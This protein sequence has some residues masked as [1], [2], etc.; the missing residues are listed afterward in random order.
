MLVSLFLILGKLKKEGLS[1]SLTVQGIKPVVPKVGK[2]VKSK[3]NEDIM[4]RLE[5]LI[6]LLRSGALTEEEFKKEKLS[7][8]GYR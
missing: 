4:Y 5:R 1:M 8:L 2:V 3:N 6:I 7:M